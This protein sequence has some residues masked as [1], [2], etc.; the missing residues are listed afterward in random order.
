MRWIVLPSRKRVDVRVQ[1]SDSIGTETGAAARA[2]IEYDEHTEPEPG[3]SATGLGTSYER[4]QARGAMRGLAFACPYIPNLP[5]ADR[6]AFAAYARWLVETVVARARAEAPVAVRGEQPKGDKA[7][8][9]DWPLERLTPLAESAIGTRWQHGPWWTDD[10]GRTDRTA[11]P[12]A[13]AG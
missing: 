13:A 5:I 3:S 8:Q 1:P 2:R 7:G 9:L 4:L 6:H 11:L 10:D 12:E